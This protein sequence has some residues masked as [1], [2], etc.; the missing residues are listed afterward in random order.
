MNTVLLVEDEPCNQTVIEDMFRFDNIGGELVVAE[1]GE[2]AILLAAR[3]KPILILMDIGLPDMTGLEATTSIRNNPDMKDTPIWVI[4]A[5]ARTEDKAKALAA[6]CAE[7]ITKPF[8]RSE[9]AQRLRQFVASRVKE[10]PSR[11]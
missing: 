4:T 6:G 3:T 9:L 8:K 10:L 5:Y 7:H 2:K 11:P 1:S